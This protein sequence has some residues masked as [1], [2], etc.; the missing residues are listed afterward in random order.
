VKIAG[1]QGRYAVENGLSPLGIECGL[2]FEAASSRVEA[3]WLR[4]TCR[5]TRGRR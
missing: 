1:Q 5:W 4:V 3:Y 2:R